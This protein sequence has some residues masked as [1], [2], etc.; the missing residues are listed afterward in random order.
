MADTPLV[1][2]GQA[3]IQA[4]S[5]GVADVEIA[6]GLRREAGHHAPIVLA[7]GYIIGYTLADEIKRRSIFFWGIVHGFFLFFPEPASGP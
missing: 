6:V 4:D 5:L 2:R 7:G 3:E 1:L